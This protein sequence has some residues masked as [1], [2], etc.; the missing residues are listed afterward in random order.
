MPYRIQFRRG[1]AAQ[2]TAA[3]PVLADGEMGIET[4]TTKFK[5]G[6]GTTA[7]TSLAY[8]PVFG[9][10]SDGS[11]TESKIATGAVTQAKLASNLSA[12]T[13]CTSSTRPA[14]P[15]VGQMI[16]ETDTNTLRIYKSTGWSTPYLEKG[17]FA[18]YLIVGGG[19]G[20]GCSNN[21]TGG[22]GG[23][24]GLLTGTTTLIPSS[25]YVVT[26]GAG[27]AG[28][29][30]TTST[31]SVSGSGSSF[32]GITAI[33]GGRGSG[34]FSSG[35]YSA[36]P[37]SG[38]SGGGAGEGTPVPLS[39]AAGTYG[40]GNAGGNYT[41]GNPNYG[42]GGG[43][44]AGA[45]GV[46][47]TATSAGN[48]GVGGQLS[49]SGTATY[50]AGGGGGGLY[51][52]SSRNGGLGGN[53]GGGDGAFTQTS[54]NGSSGTANTGGGGGGAS[55]YAGYYANGG[56]GGAG[57]VIIRYLTS[58][59]T[60]LTITG[61]TITTSGSYTIHTFNSSSSLVIA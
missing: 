48:G 9:I 12:V 23:G 58:D 10:P 2:W 25:T 53:G 41:G 14:S 45:A 1:T 5:I 61:G 28:G 54:S 18:E 7:W 6:D 35:T 30:S 22:G 11:I 52:A 8:G 20:G 59:A 13:I 55:S 31:D 3:N 36:I 4:D 37:S 40:Q 27:G 46:S 16:Y 47:G 17:P 44:G 15:Y 26:V 19:G 60:G 39:G 34:R 38:G 24:G 56:N 32:S 29:I 51:Y 43:G 33:G 57:I 21:S 49:I 42:G 50:Y